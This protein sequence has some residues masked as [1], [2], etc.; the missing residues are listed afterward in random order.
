MVEVVKNPR[1]EA[2]AQHF[3][4]AKASLAA[5]IGAERN[6]GVAHFDSTASVSD[7][8]ITPFLDAMRRAGWVPR[9]KQGL[10][11]D[12]LECPHCRRGKS[13]YA[14]SKYGIAVRCCAYCDN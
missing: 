2:M 10:L 12:A 4:A 8:Q 11:V 14:F 6:A 5:T 1:R 13:R 7:P 3:E 9:A